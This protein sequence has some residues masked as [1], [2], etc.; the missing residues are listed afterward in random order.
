MNLLENQQA[1]ERIDSV[2]IDLESSL[3]QNIVR[4]LKGYEQPIASDKW[5]L[6]KLAEI[7]KLNQENIKP[8]SQ[9]AGISQ[10]AAERMLQD[11]AE[12]A[13]NAIDPGLQYL[14]KRNLAG[15]AVA[16]SKSRNVEQAVKAM[17]RQAKDVLNKSNTTMLYKAQEA[18]KGLVNSIVKTAE[19]IADKQSFIDLLNKH[20]TAATIGT[21]SR[22][23]A[24]RKCIREFSEKGIPAFVDKKGRNWTPEAYVNMAMRNTAKNTADEVQTARCRDAGV[25]LIAI[26]SHSG[27]RPKCAKDQG[28]IFS[29]DNTSGYTE[30]VNGKKIKY[31]PWSS[32]SYGAPDGILG[33]NC[34]HHKR[35][36]VP[37]VNI[38]RYFPTEDM[39]ANNALYKE[40]QVQ[41][42]LERDVR[43]QKRECMLYDELGDEEAFEKAAVKLKQEEARLKNY[44][45]GKE[46][47]HR[48]K[49]R[50]QVVGFD[51]GTSARAVSVNKGVQKKYAKQHLNSVSLQDTA[52]QGIIKAERFES[53]KFAD[54]LLRPETEKLWPKLTPLE[55]DSAFRYTEGSGRFNRPLRGYDGSWDNFVGIGKVSLDNE[56]AEKYIRGL[57]DA[58]NKSELPKDMWLFRGSDVQS[59]AGLLGID[60]SKIVPSNISAINRKFAGMPITDQAFF[61]TGVSADSGFRD[62]ISYEILAPKGT[63]GI[64]AEPFSAFGNT[65]TW[66]EWDGKEKGV[67]VG[68]EAEFILQA[69]TSFVIKEIKEVSGKVTV[70]MEVIR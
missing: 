60:K 50:E 68:T 12:E 16:A 14:A 19:E 13:I 7:G 41:R 4:H 70:V 9:M 52:K 10:T 2:Y 40:T 17:N 20:A 57:K 66:G 33:I 56:G 34:G 67:S 28:K 5:Q 8:I 51:K 45:D 44:V 15:E 37:G 65:N 35:P 6:Q 69:G 1:A 49:D 61:S 62:K 54:K 48:R 59:L 36:F 25:N 42:A 63:K 23:Q 31:Y 64:Y 55:K 47:L 46:H 30:D 26:D 18:Y 27:A 43:K 24:M 29:L 39:D 32:S 58:I 22:Q 21:E 3:M 11:M 38:Q 53:R